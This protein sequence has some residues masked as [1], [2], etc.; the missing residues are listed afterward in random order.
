MC[1]KKNVDYVAL[2]WEDLQ[3]QINN[4]QLK[5]RRREIMLYPKFTKIIIHYLFSQHNFISKRQGSLYNTFKHD[6]ALGRLKFTS[7]GEEH[8]VYGKLVLNILVTDDIENFEAYKTFI[9]LSTNLVPPKKRRGK[10]A[11]G[12]KATKSINASRRKSKFQHQ[13]GSSSE[14]V[15]ITPEVPDEPIGKSEVSDEGFG[16]SPEVSDEAKEKTK[17][18]EDL[19]DWVSTDDETLLFDDKDKQVE[20]I[21]WKENAD[22]KHEENDEKVEEQ[23]VDEE[24]KRNDQAENEQVGVLVSVTKKK[25]PDLLQSTSSHSISSNFEIPTIQQEPFHEVK[26]SVIPKPTQ[27]PPPT[28][29]APLL[30]ARKVPTT[31]AQANQVPESEALIAILQRV[32]DLEKDVKELKQV[33]HSLK[34]RRHKDK[35]QDLPTGSDQG[36]TK[37]RTRKD[38]EPSMKFKESAKEQ[39]LD[40]VANDADEPQVD[41]IPKI[42]KQDWFKQPP[43]LETPNPDWNTVKTVDDAPEESWFKEML[44]AE[45]HPLTFDELMSTPIEFTVF[46]MNRLKLDKITRADLVGLVKPTQRKFRKKVLLFHYQDT[47]FKNSVEDVQLSVESYQ[48][49]LN[50]TKPQRSC[51]FLSTKVPYTPNFDPSGVIYEDKSNKKKADACWLG[52]NN[53]MPIRTTNL[54][55]EIS[56][57]QQRFDESFHEAW[58]RY[59]DLLR[60]CPHH[61]FTE[62]HQLDTF[63]NALNPA[64]QDSLNSAAGGS[65]LERR[66]QDVLT[67]IEKIQVNQQTSV[68]TTAMTAIL[69]QFQATPP[70]ASLKAIEEICVTCGGAHPYYQC[71]AA[72]GNT[73]LE[74]RDNIKDTFQQPRLT[75]IREDKREE[76]T[77]T[78]PELAEYTIKVLPPL[79]QK[80]KPPSQINYVVHQRDPLHLNIPYLSRMYR[81]KQQDKDEIQ[82]YKFWQMFKQLHINITLTN[83]LILILKYQKILKA[84]LSNKEKLLELANTPLN[85]NCSAVILKK[86]PKKLGDP[87]KYLISCGFSEL[88]CKALVDL[89][90]RVICTPAKIARDVFV[91]V[92]KFTFPAEFVI[93]D[94]ESDPR[95][96]LISGRP[97]LWTARALT[98]VHGE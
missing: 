34:K 54:R 28:P 4:R 11:Q 77:L 2:I 16:I 10:G 43:R 82:I 27:V 67:I 14:R 89:A 18:Q 7:K 78:D 45:K 22:K 51:P 81:E 63:Y 95:V 58:D 66:T 85:E 96:P 5:V 20:E 36:K 9:A 24:Q 15:G 92:G 93:V 44:Q 50:L 3:Y 1:S 74:F 8:Q 80:D 70:P 87:G 57:F 62:L 94:Y 26:V 56:N 31:P 88:K 60:A 75:T 42:L 29:P 38:V 23:K 73:F 30:L 52:Y 35:D 64:D 97:F 13:S 32:S 61:G 91:P 47:S 41:V 59:K 39:N 72:D 12:S 21:P 86:S 37:R 98:D 49:K 33:Y 48:R 25:K 79:V 76:E 40:N 19:D 71:L 17:A 6:R 65:L 55:N 68:V 84:L 46:A 90:N 69:K 83:A 53:D